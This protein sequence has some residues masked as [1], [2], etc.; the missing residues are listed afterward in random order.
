MM[1]RRSKQ[2][3][4]PEAKRLARQVMDLLPE[5][6][7]H[8]EDPELLWQLTWLLDLTQQAFAARLSPKARRQQAASE[9]DWEQRM[10]EIQASLRPL[11]GSRH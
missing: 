8:P 9:L 3:V 1:A 4:P 7:A 11:L 2:P 6:Q 10:S 5:V